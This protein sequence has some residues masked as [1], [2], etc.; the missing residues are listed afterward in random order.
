MCGES[1]THGLERETVEGRPSTATLLINIACALIELIS[2]KHYCPDG[3]PLYTC[4]PYGAKEGKGT[5]FYRHIVPTGLKDGKLNVLHYHWIQIVSEMFIPSPLK[6][7]SRNTTHTR[8]D[9]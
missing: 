4:R 6:A 7:V 3:T 1:R 8:H 9:P 5:S 2:V